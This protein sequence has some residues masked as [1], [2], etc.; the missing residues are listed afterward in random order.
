MSGSTITPWV[1]G[2]WKMNPM[3]ADT[4]QLIEGFK[5]LLQTNPIDEH[6]C[7][8]GVAPI[9]VALTKV[10]ADFESANRMIYTVAQDVSV[11]AG[12]GAYTGE[13]SAELLQDYQIN[14]VLVGHSERREI[15]AEHAEILNRKIKN[16]LNAGLTVIYCVG[17][18]LEQRET[19]QAESVVLQQI[20]D[21]AAVV[22]AEQWRNIVIA[23]E[24]V[25]AIGTGKTASPEDAQMMHA[26]IRAGLCQISPY[27]AQIAILY[28]GSVKPENAVELAACPDINGALVGGASLNAESFYQIAQAFA[29][30]K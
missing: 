9:A 16:A 15:F 12:M 7:H 17:E 6:R 24:P 26:Q 23:Y 5:Q 25:W 29:N 3:K 18:S 10:Q 30:T 27:G 8:L 14:Y 21:I 13:I 28:G 19:G 11:M 1:V 22:Q 2:N 20:C 4:V